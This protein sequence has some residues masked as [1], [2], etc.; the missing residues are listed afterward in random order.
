MAEL[1]LRKIRAELFFFLGRSKEHQ[2][3]TDALEALASTDADL[4]LALFN[5]VRALE[6]QGRRAE[7]VQVGLRALRI[8]PDDVDVQA[9][10]AI[11]LAHDGHVQEALPHAER[12]LAVATRRG[13]DRLRGRALRILASCHESGGDFGPALP[14]L[15]QALTAFEAAGN[16]RGVVSIRMGLAYH[17]LSVGRHAAAREALERGRLECRAVGNLLAEGYVDELLGLARARTGDVEGALVMEAEALGLAMELG[18][19]RLEMAARTVRSAI[20]FEAGRMAEALPVLREALAFPE[21]LV[22]Q[23]APELHALHAI[24]LLGLGRKGEARSEVERALELR[25]R[26][27]GMEQFEAYAF[28]AA[29]DAGIEGALAAGTKALLDRAARLPDAAMRAD[30]L[31][32]IPDNARLYARARAAGLAQ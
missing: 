25:E 13:D 27:G 7:A 17:T 9:E 30:Y 19:R 32:K 31:E 1:A 15:E 18:E 6:V 2:S 4:M 10:V 8:D 14:L 24:A 5:R 21:D 23:F 28:L 20:L 11:S 29:D 12:A 3:E 26:L 16:P 22:G